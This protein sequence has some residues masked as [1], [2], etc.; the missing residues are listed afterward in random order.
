MFRGVETG[1]WRGR[2]AFVVSALSGWS[3]WKSYVETPKE[4]DMDAFQY[5]TKCEEEYVERLVALDL[6]LAA[7]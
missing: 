6:L 4:F 1:R 2:Q 7:A 5:S 3:C